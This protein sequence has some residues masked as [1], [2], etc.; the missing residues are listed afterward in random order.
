MNILYP[1]VT[2]R[3]YALF[4]MLVQTFVV[5]PNLYFY[6]DIDECEE[7]PHGCSQ[8]CTNTPGS[9]FCNCRRGFQLVG[10]TECEG[11]IA[12]WVVVAV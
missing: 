5:N 10:T 2:Y 8:I 3:M 1:Y 11:M 9:F 4:N 12:Q 6:P 7:L